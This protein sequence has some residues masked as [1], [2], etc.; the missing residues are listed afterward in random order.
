VTPVRG[1]EGGSRPASTARTPVLLALLLCLPV[2]GF[3]IGDLQAASRALVLAG[4]EEIVIAEAGI[5][6]RARMDTGAG[7]SS[8]HAEDIE[9]LGGESADPQQHHGRMV[10]FTL[11]NENDARATITTRIER[12][13]SIRTGDCEKSRYHVYLTLT[14]GGRSERVLVNLND[15]SYSPNRLLV[16]RNWLRQGFLVD[17]S[18]NT[19]GKGP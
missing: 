5:A 1:T 19:G 9:V 11:V 17:V 15:R 12:V 3:L 6:F 10:R 8:I 14:H 16:G 2:A 4:E 13:R 18:R 7:I